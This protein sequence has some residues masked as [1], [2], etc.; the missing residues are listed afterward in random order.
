MNSQQ[1]EVYSGLEGIHLPLYIRVMKKNPDEGKDKCT[2]FENEYMADLYLIVIKIIIL[3]SLL[4]LTC[5]CSLMFLQVPSCCLLRLWFG[6]GSKC[7]PLQL[8]FVEM[9][10]VMYCSSSVQFRLVQEEQLLK[11]SCIKSWEEWDILSNLL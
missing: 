6:L 2:G 10:Y 9:F 3:N 11:S 4:P 7:Q 5:F 1:G 8:C